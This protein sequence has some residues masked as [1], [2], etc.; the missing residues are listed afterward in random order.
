MLSAENPLSPSARA[1]QVFS[2]KA[3]DILALRHIP[4]AAID[5]D[6][7][8]LT[9]LLRGTRACLALW[10]MDYWRLGSVTDAIAPPRVETTGCAQHLSCL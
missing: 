7:L 9:H 8:G 10:Q 4:H 1:K 3:S 2:P 6:A 5:M